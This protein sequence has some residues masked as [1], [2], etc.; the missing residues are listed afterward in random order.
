M[1][2]I[3]ITKIGK[4]GNQKDYSLVRN[5][6]PYYSGR[7]EGK[8]IKDTM[9]AIPRE[10]ANV[11]V[12]DG[13]EGIGDIAGTGDVSKFQF[14]GKS[15][16]DGGIPVKLPQGTFIY[17]KALKLD[18]D[19]LIKKLFGLNK[20]KDG[21]SFSELSSKYDINK[22]T[23]AINDPKTDDIEKR[24]AQMMLDNNI[25]KLAEI[26][27]LQEQKKG[28]PDGVPDIVESIMPGIGEQIEQAQMQEAKFGGKILPKA[29]N[30]DTIK[31]GNPQDSFLNKQ[32][33]KE[34]HRIKDSI[35][36]KPKGINFNNNIPIAP[37]KGQSFYINNQPVSI[38]N[39]YKGFM[40]DDW[41]KFDKPIVIDLSGDGTRRTHIDEMTKSDFDKLTKEN[42]LYIDN[43]MGDKIPLYFSQSEIPKNPK[44]IKNYLEQVD[45]QRI[46]TNKI[47][48]SIFT[49]GNKVLQVV[50]P[51]VTRDGKQYIKVKTVEDPDIDIKSLIKKTNL[52]FP[53]KLSFK[54]DYIPIE[55][56]NQ[57]QGLNQ[58][59]NKTIELPAID[60]VAKKNTSSQSNN[61][62]T[63]STPKT[64]SKSKIKQV[65]KNGGLVKY[66]NAGTVND[67]TP[68]I[69]EGDLYPAM[70]DDGELYMLRK[71]AGDE[72]EVVFKVY[73]GKR[74]TPTGENE[75]WAENPKK[76]REYI[77]ILNKHNIN[78]NEIK[79][80][81]DFQD[82]IYDITLKENPQSIYDMWSNYGQTI[83]GNK[84]PEIKKQLNDVGIKTIGSNDA[85]KI[86]FD[87]LPEDKKRKAAEIL[88]QGYVDNKVGVRTLGL[89]PISPTVTPNITET[90]TVKPKDKTPYTGENINVTKPN[91]VTNENFDNGPWYLPDITNFTGALTD[92]I[93]K[94]RPTMSK[95]DSEIPNYALMDPTRQLAAN[96]EAM[97]QNKD[98]IEDTVAG[99]IGA[100]AV[101]GNFSKGFE[102][103]AN[104]L[105]QTENQNVGITNQA[106]ANASQIKNNE[107]ILNEQLKQKY[108]SELANFSENYD[109][110]VNQKK[111]RQIGTFNRGWD[112]ASKKKMLEQVMFPQVRQNAI[113]GDWSFSGKGR[114]LE[115]YDTYVNPLTNQEEKFDYN[116]IMQQSQDIYDKSYQSAL[117]KYPDKQQA[118]RIA[119]ANR[120]NFFDM[121]MGSIKSSKKQKEQMAE[122]LYRQEFGG[123]IPDLDFID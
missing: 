121:A 110:E 44:D 73:K 84:Y 26:A 10:E 6:Y 67:A 60:V 55:E 4:N 20:K 51:N 116:S 69:K 113:T 49:K 109:K 85:Y 101:I 29:Q 106:L 100:A 103:A 58:N 30:G 77:D 7:D 83:E 94:Y 38:K 32:N 31:Y 28:W 104:I 45:P 98:F 86:D 89:N 117:L 18:D 23:D 17:S 33:E 35:D 119:E 47:Q 80:A 72:D 68:E 1:A 81:K 65:F 52:G 15:H 96:Q 120:D 36:N 48:G 78:P 46:E 79:S 25:Q 95:I 24:S 90:P 92:V 97:A 112:N 93:H 34:L 74:T 71:K 39:T 63:T 8:Q 41:I 102:N 82:K 2:R 122:M 70:L 118:T 12:E 19:E 43:G 105:A 22:F 99:N 5:M 108:L 27:L 54:S 115:G 62:S 14:K 111:W 107:N 88:K 13:E 3:K 42:K 87:H 50:N 123:T 75:S 57:L 114:D 21:W 56:Y 64:V 40:G 9:G 11:E 53:I 61:Q 66:Q 37:Q 16:A 59:T 91:F 76:L